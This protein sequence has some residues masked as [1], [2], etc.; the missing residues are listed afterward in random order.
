MRFTAALIAAVASTA[1]AAPLSIPIVGDLLGGSGTDGTSGVFNIIYTTVQGSGSGSG[2]KSISI[3]NGDGS[4][5]FRNR[6]GRPRRLSRQWRR[7]LRRRH[8][9]E[10]PRRLLPHRGH[11]NAHPP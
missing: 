8:R 2:S 3:V 1:G 4:E 6:S 5:L 7:L 9:Q 11:R 10:C